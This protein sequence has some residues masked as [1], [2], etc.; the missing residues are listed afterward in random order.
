MI[1][2]RPKP[3]RQ[4]RHILDTLWIPKSFGLDDRN[5][6]GIGE[7]EDAAAKERCSLEGIAANK[8]TIPSGSF[9]DRFGSPSGKL[10]LSL[11]IGE[12]IDQT[13]SRQL[14]QSLQ[15]TVCSALTSTIKHKL[16]LHHL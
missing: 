8:Y 1:D 15:N 7:L 6:A 11:D 14:P 2:W 16:A 12:P 4:S 9:V 10:S 13:F 5:A 3:G